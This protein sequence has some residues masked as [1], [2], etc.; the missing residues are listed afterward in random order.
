MTRIVLALLLSIAAAAQTQIR[1]TVYLGTGE[2]F[3]GRIVVLSPNMTTASG[4][5]VLR[6]RTELY[7]SNGIISIDLE[8]N[9]TSTPPGTRYVV[10]YYPRRG[11][12]WSEHWNV[13]TSATPVLVSDVRVLTS[14]PASSTGPRFSDA[15]VPAGSIDGI[16]RTFQLA[17]APSPPASLILTRNGLV[18]KLGVDYTLAGNSVTFIPEQTPQPG[19][20]VLAWY[21]Y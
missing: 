4:R 11:P 2:P 12:A 21:R 10:Q 13:P 17:R 1:D 9:D 16:R 14:P 18:L 19:D 3:E 15:E 20:I 7:I 6:G 8:P 5:T